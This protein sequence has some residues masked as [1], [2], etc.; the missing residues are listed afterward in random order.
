MR[1]T[2]HEPATETAGSGHLAGGVRF[3]L[4]SPVVKAALAAT[5]TI[6]FFNFVFHSLFVLY[7]TRSLEVRPAVLGAVVGAAAVGGIL[8]SIVTGPLTR[9]IGV[10]PAFV[11]GCILFPL[12]LVLVPAASGTPA[13]V[14][15]L[16]FIAEFGVGLG[17]M[18][19]DISGASISATLV[20]D[21]LRARVSGAY[22]V[23]N[24][25]VRPLG[26]LLGGTLG[27]MIGLRPTLWI[28]VIGAL[29]GFLWLLRSP[30]P[31]LRTLDQA[32]AIARGEERQ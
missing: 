9:H 26:A 23:V 17:V 11:L 10:G 24:Y 16:L 28:G 22:M 27:A 29:T 1:I 4:G 18:I 19:L 5:A 20:P 21:R 3:I 15:A 12:P 30:I 31:R 7:A 32:A 8:G 14:L 6:N 13:Q 2:P 25:G